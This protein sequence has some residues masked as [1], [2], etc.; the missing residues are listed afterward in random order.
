MAFHKHSG[1]VDRQNFVKPSTVMNSPTR[2]L[3]VLPRLVP[4]HSQLFTARPLAL[5]SA[6][7]LV[8][9]LSG[10]AQSDNFDSYSS[11][12]QLGAAGWILSSLNPALVSTTFPAVGSGKG[13]RIQANPVPGQAP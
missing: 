9:P 7:A 3:G 10:P 6:V 11:A 13:L 1:P 2:F 8:I 5:I 12:T 4:L